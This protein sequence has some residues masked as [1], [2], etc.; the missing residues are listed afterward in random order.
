MKHTLLK[1]LL[2]LL[3]FTFTPAPALYAQDNV[4]NDNTSISA[5]DGSS[6]ES[7]NT[8][9]KNK[10]EK[11]EENTDATFFTYTIERFTPAFFSDC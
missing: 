1:F 8:K 6:D 5:G 2:P 11:D 7:G 4:A 10:K 3:L 9:K